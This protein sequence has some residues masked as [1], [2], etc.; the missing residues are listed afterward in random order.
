MP[1]VPDPPADRCGTARTSSIQLA[2]TDETAHRIAA[3]YGG[4]EREHPF[5]HDRYKWLSAFGVL[6]DRADELAR[7]L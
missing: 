2:T 5:I 3:L 7:L 4:Y 6:M 1:D